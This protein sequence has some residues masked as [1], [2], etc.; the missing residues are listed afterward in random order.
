MSVKGNE[1]QV[2]KTKKLI[3][4]Y[5]IM[6]G[7]IGIIFWSGMLVSSKLKSKDY[8]KWMLHRLFFIKEC[9]K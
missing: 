9:I 4:G 5:I 8:V 6:V 3:E 7:F 1:C 2:L